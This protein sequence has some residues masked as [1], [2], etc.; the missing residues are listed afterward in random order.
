MNFIK[1]AYF[2]AILL[3]CS[4][5]TSKQKQIIKLGYKKG[6]FAQIITEKGTITAKLEYL[7]SP[8]AVANFIGLAKGLIPNTVKKTGMPFYDSLK[9]QRVLKGYMLIGGCPKGDGSGNPGYYFYDDFNKNLK[10]DKPGILSFENSGKNNF[11][12]VFNITLKATPVLDNKNLIFGEVVS[13]IDVLN[14]IQ[15]GELIKKI[16]IIKIGKKANKFN[17]L[18]VFEKNGFSNMIKY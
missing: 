5:Y 16:E 1:F 10:H 6:I 12:C 4:C 7:K 13:G 9:F 3:L 11:G 17:P 18:K 15:Q 14:L 8:L 2:C